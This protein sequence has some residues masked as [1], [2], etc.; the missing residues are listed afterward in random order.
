MG[1]AGSFRIAET[2]SQQAEAGPRLLVRE[3]V[4]GQDEPVA[5]GRAPRLSAG[6]PDGL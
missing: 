2:S 3:E 6:G 1:V 4:G 5:V